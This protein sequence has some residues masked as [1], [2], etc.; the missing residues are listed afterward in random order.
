MAHR[1]GDQRLALALT[2][3]FQRITNGSITQE[4]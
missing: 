1:G 2:D 3:L 4:V